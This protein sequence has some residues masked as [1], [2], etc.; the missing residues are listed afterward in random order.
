MTSWHRAQRAIGKAIDRLQSRGAVDPFFRGHKDSRWELLPS[1]ARRKRTS[2]VENRLYYLFVS[3]GGHLIPEDATTWDTLFLMQHH[4]LQTRLLDWTE[5][6][7]VALYFAIKGAKRESAVW[8]LDPYEL[9]SQTLERDVVIHLE[10]SF[11]EGYERYFVQERNELF[12]KFPAS[13]AA[14]VGSHRSERMRMQRGVFTVH[15]ELSRPLEA[16]FPGCLQKIPIPKDAIA[17]AAQFLRLSG[18]NE[19][20]LFP[21]LD[22]IARHIRATEV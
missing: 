13:V 22:G 4:G 21:D 11:P 6:F 12:G 16:L 15:R 1:L 7:S 20:T 8:V 5:N 10:T 3:L 2:A 18:V 14:I 17:E 9:N 19:S